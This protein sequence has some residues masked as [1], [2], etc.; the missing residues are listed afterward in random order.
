MIRHKTGIA[1]F[2][3]LVQGGLVD[4][5]IYL[6]SGPPGSG[7]TTFGIQFLAY[8]ATIGELGLYV[9]LS[10][11]PHNIV[12][13][14]SNYA[15]NI[16]TLIKLKKLLFLDLGPTLEYGYGDELHSVITP[17]FDSTNQPAPE[18]EAPSPFIV[19]K[20]ISNFVRQY[21]IQRLVIDSVSAIRFTSEKRSQ[22]EKE[23]S[24]FMRNLKELGCTTILLS[25]LT[26]PNTYST[27]QF[28][29]SGVIFMHNFM[30]EDSMTRAVQI[31]KMRGTEHD[32]D[33]RKVTFTKQGLQ[34]LERM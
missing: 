18:A 19:Y 29:A 1:G 7:K 4:K 22:E 12:S 23:M 17:S 16:P 14:M 25:E 6:V 2:D 10:E 20:E 30:R 13:D 32:C 11:S 15:L 3:E 26:D 8:G 34:V 33:M 28:A 5:R 9:T 21:D 31:I 27:E 24:R